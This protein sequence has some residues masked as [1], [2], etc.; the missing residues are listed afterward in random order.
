MR[1]WNCATVQF[2]PPPPRPLSGSET[3][4]WFR[5]KF[6]PNQVRDELWNTDRNW[7]R[8][9]HFF[10]V[11]ISSLGC[12]Y[13]PILS[14]TEAQWSI[15]L[16]II[17]FCSSPKHQ[18]IGGFR[19]STLLAAKIVEGNDL[20]TMSYGRTKKNHSHLAVNS[21]RRRSPP[22][23]HVSKVPITTGRRSPSTPSKLEAVSFAQHPF[24]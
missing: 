17:L 15:C 6:Y 23:N 3:F 18:K 22:Q 21:T 5:L 16:I 10:L 9:C 8:I 4:T 7:C 14:T 12:L 13:R 11:F 1:V 20:L 24:R 19:K 2:P